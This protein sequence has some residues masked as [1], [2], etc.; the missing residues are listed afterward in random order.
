MYRTYSCPECYTPSYLK[1]REVPHLQRRL[2]KA[3]ALVD[4]ARHSKERIII[5]PAGEQARH[6]CGLIDFRDVLAGFG[7]NNPAK[8][9]TRH[10]DLPVYALEDILRMKPETVMVVSPFAGQAIYDS[11]K[12]LSRYFRLELF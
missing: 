3:E 2:S 6:L 12:P 11:L 1:S 5:W 10:C 8:Q 4:Q 7:D 9:G